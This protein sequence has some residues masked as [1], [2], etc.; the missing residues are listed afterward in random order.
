MAKV[1]FGLV[2]RFLRPEAGQ[3]TAQ[4]FTGL[5]QPQSAWVHPGPN[6]R[7]VYQADARG[8]R[9]PDFSNAGYRY[10]WAERARTVGMPERFAQQALGHSSKAIVFSGK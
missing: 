4:T 2:L 5:A 3:V 7:L 9:I 6:G 1:F 8:N 10:A